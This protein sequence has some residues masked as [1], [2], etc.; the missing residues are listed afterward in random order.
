MAAHT[1]TLLG[2]SEAALAAI[3]GII[4][5]TNVEM[6]Y[7]NVEIPHPKR[8]ARRAAKQLLDDYGL[9]HCTK[10]TFIQL[11]YVVANFKKDEAAKPKKYGRLTIDM[12]TAASLLGYIIKPIISSFGNHPDND[13]L[14][15][16]HGRC[17]SLVNTHRSCLR[18]LFHRLLHENMFLFKGDDGLFSIM[19]RTGRLFIETDLA[20]CDITQGP[21]VVYYLLEITPIEFR[22]VMLQLINQLRAPVKYGRGKT[23]MKFTP[24]DVCE[25]SGSVLTT[26]LNNVANLCIGTQIM[27]IDYSAM[28]ELE[29]KTSLNSTLKHCGWN[30]TYHIASCFQQCTFLKHNP[31]FTDAGE[32][33]AITNLGVMLRAIGRK[34]GDFPGSGD[35]F[36]RGYMFCCALVQSM[37]HCGNHDVL[38]ALQTRFNGPGCAMTPEIEKFKMFLGEDIGYIPLEQLALRYSLDVRDLEYMIGMILCGEWNVDCPAVRRIMDLD[39][40][41]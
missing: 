10:S 13:D 41:M 30:V 24:V 11:G 4:A 35:F 33:D 39:Y 23:S 9:T 27:S 16:A 34:C 5:E 12:S 32:V 28:S 3:R 38:K 1:R 14:V 21:A 31:V 29:A 8:A 20:S 19:C 37:K 25:Y 22:P 36:V 7:R 15:C 18:R 26:L 17:L 6:L 40:G 2:R